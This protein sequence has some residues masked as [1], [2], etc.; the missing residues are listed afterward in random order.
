MRAGKNRA[1]V[2]AYFDLWNTGDEA[3]AENLLA[4]DFADHAHPEVK[5]LDSFKAALKKTREAFPDFSVS[6]DVVTAEGD[7]VTVLG[8]T[9]RTVN[10]EPKVAEVLW[11]FRIQ[12]KKIAEWKTGVIA[13]EK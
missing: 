4:P 13:L 6:L 8:M 2:R 5:G 10:G 9:R 7:Y 1:L 12:G 3:A 11:L